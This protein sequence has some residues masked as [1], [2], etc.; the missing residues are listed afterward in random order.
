MTVPGPVSCK[1]I[2]NSLGDDASD[3]SDAGC[4]GPLEALEAGGAAADWTLTGAML[5]TTLSVATGSGGDAAGTLS[6][7][8]ADVWFGAGDTG[9]SSSM[10]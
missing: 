7:K 10:A 4:D 6:G 2:L 1:R 9:V 5:G 3:A 8:A